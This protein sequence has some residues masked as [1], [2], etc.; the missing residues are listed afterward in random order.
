MFSV[1]GGMLPPHM[2]K[3]G[4]EFLTKNILCI[5][6]EG[7]HGG[8]SRSLLTALRR[9]SRDEFNVSVWCR[10]GGFIED[11][12]RK[13]GI[14][15]EVEPTMPRLTP[16]GKWYINFLLCLKFVSFQ[17][18]QSKSFRFK[19]LKAVENFDVIHC[20]HTSLVLVMC[21]LK[22][23]RPNSKV[24][25][26][27]RTMPPVNWLSRWLARKVSNVANQ[28][29]FI[30]SNEKNHFE[31]L[32]GH[33][34]NGKILFNPVCMGVSKLPKCMRIVSSAS[35][36]ILMLSNFSHE[37]GTD[38]IIKL[39]IRMREELGNNVHFYVAGN[40][41][42]NKKKRF[43]FRRKQLLSK[44]ELLAFELDK[45]VTLLGHCRYPE[46]LISHCDLLIKPTRENNPWGRDIL[47]AL[48]GGIP[49]I[50]VGFF[51][52]FVESGVTGLLQKSYDLEGMVKWILAV[53][54]EPWKLQRM[55]ENAQ[56]R[57][58]DMCDPAVY[59]L[60]L[61]KTWTEMSLTK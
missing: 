38:R 16:V 10:L 15:C 59:A 28:L 34:V 36:K 53:Q 56:N 42:P 9:V 33:S 30:T 22:W 50:S 39:A 45:T 51:D 12:Y 17:W 52:A 60:K 18:M 13:C 23:K 37:R 55:G 61:Q 48:A 32:I 5:D 7:G 20:N 49:V 14:A 24:V 8:S 21:W 46:R 19:L 44:S 47:E 26:H 29:I 25:F 40:G 27:V 35:L 1:W 57:I 4:T 31:T 3:T 43:G 2:F 11:E 54:A 6:I 58:K 41:P